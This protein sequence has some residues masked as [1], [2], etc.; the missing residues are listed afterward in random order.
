[1]NKQHTLD[2]DVLL[3]AIKDFEEEYGRGAHAYI[4][5]RTGIHNT[6]RMLE[7]EQA[8]SL[9]TWAKLHASMPDDFPPPTMQGERIKISQ[10]ARDG[11]N[12]NMSFGGTSRGDGLSQLDRELLQLLAE[13]G[14]IAYKKRIR[15]ELLEIKRLTGGE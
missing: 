8:P 1:M 14:P 6:K 7:G 4:L 10:K 9:D 3:K 2:M 13:Y 15:K 5:K 11:A 12:Q